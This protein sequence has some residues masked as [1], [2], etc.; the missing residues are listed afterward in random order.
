MEPIDTV[1]EACDIRDASSC[2]QLYG[3]VKTAVQTGLDEL[4]HLQA[5]DPDRHLP[6]RLVQQVKTLMPAFD[7]VW[8]REGDK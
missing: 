8:G 4:L 6:A 5:K 1:A 2:M 7:L 3:R